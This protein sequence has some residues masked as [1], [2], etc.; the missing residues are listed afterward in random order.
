MLD[1]LGRISK[2]DAAKLIVVHGKNSCV[3]QLVCSSTF[4]NIKALYVISTKSP[5]ARIQFPPRH[6]PC[7]TIAGKSSYSHGI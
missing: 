5:D 6:H 3:G 7:H 2:H 1:L 4:A